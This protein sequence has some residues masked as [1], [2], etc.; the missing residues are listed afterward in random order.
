MINNEDEV[1]KH[2]GE[3]NYQLST[4]LI[5][6]YC[7]RLGIVISNY[8]NINIEYM[9]ARIKNF[10]LGYMYICTCSHKH[11]RTY[12]QELDQFEYKK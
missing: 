6:L 2:L 8:L 5:V 1:C 10:I 3:V 9:T 11:L 12:L 4:Y 7:V